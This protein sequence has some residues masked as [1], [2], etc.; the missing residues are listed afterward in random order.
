MPY[1]F[2]EIQLTEEPGGTLVTLVFQDTLKKEDYE[3]FVPQ[4]EKIMESRDKIRMLIQLKDF[5]GWSAGALWEETKFGA[6]HFTDIDR[7]AIVGDKAWEKTMAGFIAPFTGAE[8]KYFDMMD[9][10]LAKGWVSQP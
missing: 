2:D 5:K 9:L 10:H 8:V 4:V 7:L 3:Y 6:R 1:A